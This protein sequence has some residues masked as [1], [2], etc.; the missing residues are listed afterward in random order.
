[1]SSTVKDLKEVLDQYE[2]DHEVEFLVVDT[3]GELIAIDLEKTVKG[4]KRLLENFV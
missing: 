2:D 3:K 1:M 4:L